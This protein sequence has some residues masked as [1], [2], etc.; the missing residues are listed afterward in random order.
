MAVSA[1]AFFA[2]GV[3]ELFRLLIVLVMALTAFVADFFHVPMMKGTIEAHGRACRDIQRSAS[4]AL[5][6][7]RWP[8]RGAGSRRLVMA[9][10]AL[11][12]VEFHDD[13]AA[14][15]FQSEVFLRETTVLHPHVAR[16]ADLLPFGEGLGMLVMGKGN[17]GSLEWA[18]LRQSF[19]ED[20]IGTLDSIF[21]G[22]CTA[23]G[24]SGGARQDKKGQNK[25]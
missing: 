5:P 2:L 16:F 15:V 6:A 11:L 21:V 1:C 9:G 12:M 10:N 14:L 20:D 8:G 24:K 22:T 7:R 4:V 23:A 17:G 13:V 19:D 18:E 3:E 25:G